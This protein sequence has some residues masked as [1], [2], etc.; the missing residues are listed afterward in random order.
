MCLHLTAAQ[1][2]VQYQLP[3]VVVSSSK[4]SLS[5]IE[6]NRSVTVIDSASINNA[7]PLSIDEALQMFTTTE[8]H[9]RG[10]LGVQTD[11]GIRG[12]TFSQQA[13]LLNGIRINDPQTAHH[14]FDIPI[15]MS[16]VKQIEIV[17]GPSS[18]HFGP[19]AFGG[20]INIVTA[21]ETPSTTFELSGGQFGYY[22][23]S[24]L[25]GFSYNQL[26]SSTTV[27]Y[28]KSDGYRYDTEFENV[29]ATTSNSVMLPDASFH[30]LLGYVK[31]N[32]GAFDF[33]SPGKNNP[34]HEKTETIFSGMGTEFSVN[35]WDITVHS[36]Y[37]HHYDDFI[38]IITNPSYSHNQHNTNVYTVDGNGLHS[39]TSSLLLKTSAEA[40]LDNI[41]STKLGI[42]TR[43]SLALSAV[44]RWN[45]VT[46]LSIDAGLRFDIRS[47]Y[48]NQV[49]PIISAGYFLNEENKIFVSVGTS[50]RAPSY[51]DLYYSD[52]S[53]VG[54]P[55]LKPEKGT[56]YEAGI[57]SFPH[58][59]LV[60]QFSGFLRHQD[61]LIDFVLHQPNGKYY[62]VNFTA[63]DVKGV[64]FQSTWSN[65]SSRAH[66]FKQFFAGYTFLESIVD[67]KGALKTR[68]SLTH[69]KHQL[70][71]AATFEVPS[72][73]M[74]TF[75]GSYAH[76]SDYDDQT[77]F[78]VTVTKKIEMVE[79]IVK[80][81]NVFNSSYEEIPGIPLPG[82]WIIGKIR[83][84]IL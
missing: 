20:T 58:P 48:E 65:S 84:T 54:N 66:W 32:F 22:S 41:N 29:T 76:R 24:G 45:P 5:P 73:M 34:S 8:L 40:N 4:F 3:Q 62:A 26:H 27:Q 49:H 36:T 11:I 72:D 39:F 53:T 43:K 64:E 38:Y 35:D 78:D 74:I 52:P 10:A 13:I 19:D 21:H 75:G 16:S 47:D 82:R 60:L 42:H 56:S 15:P 51:T 12:S 69:P 71:G 30:L 67:T 59:A 55:N 63:L 2:T 80:A 57:S 25:Y 33:Y 28:E 46:P 61:N 50:F 18:S 81:M 14:N 31:K 6:M 37:R 23:G 79:M 68:Y 17:R 7:A 1:D 9:R 83:W 44:T 70:N 77:N